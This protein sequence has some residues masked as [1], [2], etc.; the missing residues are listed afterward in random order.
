MVIN[1]PPAAEAR[2]SSSDIYNFNIRKYIEHN[3]DEAISLGFT[4]IDIIGD[5]FSKGIPLVVRKELQSLGYTVNTFSI[6]W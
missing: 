6:S 1:I 4:N 2:K 5:N 3:I